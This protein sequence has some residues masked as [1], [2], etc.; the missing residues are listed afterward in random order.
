MQITKHLPQKIQELKNGT[1]LRIVIN[2]IEEGSVI[3]LF[4]IVLDVEQNI[5]KPEVSEAFTEALNR[6]TVFEVD[7]KKTVVEGMNSFTPVNS[8]VFFTDGNV[9]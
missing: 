7:L 9:H 3:V 5:T 6:S 2:S 4:D 8:N 1:K